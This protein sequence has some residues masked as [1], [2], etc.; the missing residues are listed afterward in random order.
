[1]LLEMMQLLIYLVA[2]LLNL[3]QSDHKESTGREHSF[4]LAPDV[5]VHDMAEV[6]SSIPHT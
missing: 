1:M 6:C 4:I 3:V 5:S 2:F